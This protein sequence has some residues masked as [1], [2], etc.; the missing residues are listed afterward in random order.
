M[1]ILDVVLDLQSLVLLASRG[2]VMIVF[3]HTQF[4]IFGLLVAVGCGGKGGGKKG[5]PGPQ[6]PT[7]SLTDE[8][9]K[10]FDAWKGSLLKSCDAS[11]AFDG[12]AS[13]GDVGLDARQVLQ[14]SGR[15]LVLKS[16]QGAFVVFGQPRGL[17]GS[18]ESKISASSSTEINGRSTSSEFAAM[19]RR[20]G[21]NCQV[22]VG[23][24]VVYETEIWSALPIALSSP[25]V[26]PEPSLSTS[27]LAIVE[28][29]LVA[30]GL[31][32]A[33]I[34]SM[35]RPGKHLEDMLAPKFGSLTPEQRQQLFPVSGGQT[36]SMRVSAVLQDGPSSFVFDSE[37]DAIRGSKDLVEGL[38][39][40]TGRAKVDVVFQVPRVFVGGVANQADQG[41]WTVA[42]DIH[43]MPSGSLA[44]AASQRELSVRAA[45]LQGMSEKTPARFNS[46]T[47]LRRQAF[48][49]G[50]LFG[51][52]RFAPSFDGVVQPCFVFADSWGSALDQDDGLRAHMARLLEGVQGGSE[53]DLNGWQIALQILIAHYA[54]QKADLQAR[55]D[56]EGRSPLVVVAS[57]Y[58]KVLADSG[59]QNGPLKGSMGF[60]AERFAFRW[61]MDGAQIADRT[62]MG[63]LNAA[64]NTY[65]VLPSSTMALVNSLSDAP[66]DPVHSA[67]VTYAQGLSQAAKDRITA[68][69]AKAAA[70]GVSGSFNTKKVSRVLQDRVSE[71]TF[72]LW[73]ANLTAIEA[74]Q[75]KEKQRAGGEGRLFVEQRQVA[76][77]VDVALKDDWL[78]SE[79]DAAASFGQLAAL[80]LSCESRVTVS[81]QIS[82]QD[83]S[84]VSKAAG[85]LLDPAFG[86]RYVAL[87]TRLAERLAPL[88]DFSQ[89]RIR[90]TV[91]RGFF[92][93][94]WA[95]VDLPNFDANANAL[96]ELLTRYAS[97][98]FPESFE[99][100]RAIDDLV[101][102]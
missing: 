3:S 43:W 53:I 59:V 10:N 38:S 84:Q 8:Q 85:R 23:N 51:S 15:S 89:R 40:L 94:I 7:L 52:G 102:D 11:S 26:L 5:S 60:L 45:A 75:N 61:A 48:E 92:G 96:G 76:D 82:C 27:S 97:A 88:Q 86:G 37:I 49:Q 13:K 35:T 46:C 62:M 2:V 30:H 66:L 99:L 80:S 17:E 63:F 33:A 90:D 54:E 21:S 73:E 24:E 19:A 18:Q 36:G 20:N 16:D 29:S 22:L 9:R 95:G 79:F 32:D 71:D 47:A 93:P 12:A 70:I 98:D 57:R 6:N 69:V 74:F 44:P 87:A 56:P 91:V 1:G 34:G 39:A 81:A 64:S 25:G 28:G 68:M 100:E 58:L 31:L 72:G 41:V 14:A 67:S 78:T 4:L 65:G 77:V 55:L 83:L 101:R 50:A 42:A